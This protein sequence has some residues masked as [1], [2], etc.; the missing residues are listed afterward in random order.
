M[1]A[2]PT[3]LAERGGPSGIAS[4]VSGRA[5]AIAALVV[6]KAGKG[7]ATVFR[8]SGGGCRASIRGR[9]LGGGLLTALRATMARVRQ[10]ATKGGG[11]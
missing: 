7:R 2:S 1:A 11:L 5:I 6:T 3:P 8:E 4:A 9:P 10:K